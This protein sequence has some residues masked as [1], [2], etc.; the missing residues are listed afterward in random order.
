MSTDE[1]EI[2]VLDCRG[3]EEVHQGGNEEGS[4][5]EEPVNVDESALENADFVGHSGGPIPVLATYFASALFGCLIP[6]EVQDF[7]VN[8]SSESLEH[9]A[10]ISNKP[11][12]I[13]PIGSAPIPI[14]LS[15]IH[16][17]I[18]EGGEGVEPIV[19][20]ISTTTRYV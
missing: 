14:P 20:L 7:I 16:E 1:W 4:C 6:G 12:E 15:P 5:E 2:P 17:E 11:I 10:P 3:C 19:E 9:G 8:A 13:L 18:E